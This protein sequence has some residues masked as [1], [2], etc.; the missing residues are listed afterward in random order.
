MSQSDLTSN[1]SD[2][3]EMDFTLTPCVAC[4]QTSTENEPMVGCDS[5]KG[6]FHY[7]CVGVT[8]AVKTEKHWFCADTVCQ[9]MGKKLQEKGKKVKKN[10]NR[11]T[12][13]SSTVP[14]Q[15]DKIKAM[16]EEFKRKM[17]ELDLEKILKEKEMELKLALQE[18]RLQMERDLREKE[19]S[20]EKRLLERAMEE[21]AEHLE[22]MKVM[23]Q[24]YQEVMAGM[25]DAIK[26]LKLPSQRP[27]LHGEDPQEG[28]SAVDH[29]PLRNPSVI[30]GKLLDK[31]VE[32]RP[33]KPAEKKKTSK[34]TAVAVEN[35]DTSDEDGDDNTDDEEVSEP[36]SN[37]GTVS[38]GLGQ[39]RTG[40]TRMQLTARSGVTK[41]LP[42][43]A[44]KAEDW[45]LFYGT[46]QASN[47]ACGFTDVENLVRLQECLK[48]PALES[49]RGQLILPKSV[50]K[51]MK[52]LRQLYGRPELLLQ[53]HLERVRKLESPKPDKLASFIPFGNAVEQL[54]EHLEA[55]NLQQHLINP[56][57]I[58]DLVDKLPASDKR[59]WVR[60]KR[61]KQ[62]VTLRTFT[63]FIARIVDEVCEANVS[64]EQKGESKSSMGT[65]RENKPRTKERGVLFNHGTSSGAIKLTEEKVQRKPCKACHR[66]DHRLR[67]CEDFRNMAYNDRMDLVT[68]W[69]LCNI[70]LNDHGNAPCKFKIRCNVGN[71]QQRHNPLLHPL[72]SVVGINAHI[73]AASAVLF[74]MIPVRLHCGENSVTTLA[75]LDEGASVTLIE[76]ELA[77]RLGLV[78]T[79]EQLTIT[80]TADITREE[81]GSRCMDVM[82]SAIGGGEKVLLNSVR[83]VKSLLLPKQSLDSFKISQQ[84]TYLKNLPLLS[85][86]GARPGLLIGLNNLDSFAPIEVRM[87]DSG[88]PVAVRCKLGW[89]V[90]GPKGNGSPDRN[91]VLSFHHIVSNE[92]LHDLLRSQYVLEETV[93]TTKK[94]TKEDERAL[95]ILRRTTRRVGVHFETGLLWKNNE[96][97]FPDSWQMAIKRMTQLE[98][99]LERN[100]EIYENVRKQIVEYQQKGYAHLAT[101]EELSK[102]DPSKVWYLPLNVVLNPRKPGKIRLVWD[103]AATVEGVSLNSQLLKGP[104]MLTPLVS[105]IVGFR[106][107]RVAFG[108]DVREMYHQLRIIEGD[109]QAQRFV[110]RAK[111]TDPPSV[112]VMDVATFG[113]TCSPCS[114][115]F[116][117]NLNAKENADEYPEAA[118]AILNRHYVDDY[119]D[120]T[121]TVEEAIRRARDV[122][123]VHSKG[124]FELRNWVSNSPEV[125]RSLGEEKVVQAIHFGRDKDTGN[126]RVLGIIWNPDQDTFSFSA[127]HRDHLREYLSGNEKPT[128][129]IVLSCVMGFFD[130]L[131]LL[132]P[133]T[134]HGKIL[135]QDLWRSGSSWDEKVDD[136]CWTKWK[137]WVELLPEVESIRIPRCYFGDSRWSA[138]ESLELH[139]FTDASEYAYGCVGYLRAVIED[140]VK[141][142]LI[143]SRAKVAPLKRQSVPRLELMAAVLGARMLRTI[144][145]THS[146]KFHHH[147]MWTDSQTVRSWIRSD[148][149]KFKQFVAFRVGEVLELTKPTDWYWIPS[150]LN[151]ADVL[152]KWG[153]H[154]PLDSRSFWFT[155]PEFLY[156]S[157]ETWPAQPDSV[158]ETNEEVRAFVLHHGV[159]PKQ[160]VINSERFSRWTKLLRSTAMVLRF[161]GNCR[162][163][164]NGQPLLTIMAT[165]NQAKLIKVRLPV[166]RRPLQQNELAQAET[167]LWKLVQLESFPDETAVLYNKKQG[168][169]PSIRI[170]KS[171][172]LYKLT[173]IVDENG[174]I[175]VGGRMEASE[176]LSFDKKYPIILGRNHDITS[177][178]ILHYHERCAHGNRET[179]CNELRQKF[180]IPN[181][182]TAIRQA[183]REC[184]K[185]KVWHSRPRAPKMAPLP[186][187]RISQQLRPFSA[188]GVDFL[189]PIEVTIGS[190]RVEKRWVALFTCLTVRAI[191]LEVAHSLSSQSCLMAIRRFINRFGCP[192]EFF[193]DNGTNFK[194]AS[195]E[196]MAEI[197]RIQNACA[198]GVTSVVTKWHF[199]PPGAPH[200]G[201]V[202]ERMVRSVKETMAALCDGRKLTDEI[203]LTTLSQAEEIINSRPLTY[204][205]Q[206]SAETEALTPTHFLRGI[207]TKADIMLD[208]Q[209]NAAEALRDKY[210]RSLYLA[211]RMWE[212]WSKEYLPTIN[213]RSKWFADQKD[214]QVGDLVFISDGKNRKNWTRGIV[215]EVFAGRDGRIRQANVK[216][217]G[218]VYRR[219]TANLA[220]LEIADGKSGKSDET[221]P[222]LRA[223]DC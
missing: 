6:W 60:Y 139:M 39:Q 127:E 107:R 199:N 38:Y 31:K 212:R 52:K 56:I 207:V 63:D 156:Q 49:V 118:A 95:N 136:I 41:K 3:D 119:Y 214:L 84:Y 154:S 115:Q 87:G 172:V 101:Q 203:L 188:V 27:I 18:K 46:F 217:A 131:G 170:G 10:P 143:M 1:H 75:F 177:L 196:L 98:K 71:C 209:V 147:I 169:V 173:P 197:N 195:K 53:S 210:K 133:F 201:G 7:R 42:M 116:V 91:G 73:Q 202:W 153:K 184:M 15:H 57:L 100:P 178:L 165:A 192:N 97:N 102:S 106:E 146:I 45:P 61:K 54:C 78:G 111:K 185:C 223:G 86:S 134:I 216:T 59:E 94:E 137:R 74:R 20:Q 89:T 62:E 128:K 140:T 43:F 164:K 163:K 162:R 40:P 21:K 30:V 138:V 51:V 19:L 90:Y 83:T 17:D 96:V 24:S 99:R 187:Q 48:G 34:D 65:I 150:K 5:C 135:V 123:L 204:L 55:A 50:P 158:E 92:A 175:R 181:L 215:E 180:H 109:K 144:I 126:E 103:A 58:Q 166:V 200:M 159:A 114:A 117:K 33:K 160:S 220:V 8:E 35:T 13:K 113:S 211:D 104:D 29:T 186:I 32:S 69:K 25:D 149:H 14:T 208:G 4:K 124:G 179:V 11:A 44:G 213:H 67:Y 193:S 145:D 37:G 85:Y 189:G 16:E 77:N 174:V 130:P 64:I 151:A 152:T 12:A 129:R 9:E 120:S 36:E 70:C 142:C 66:S 47:E 26:P 157:K 218:G 161:I 79:P 22:K 167:L 82:V 190:R 125:L 68:K 23:Q 205:P 122:K 121:D 108:A 222:E 183:V 80:W 191:H 219:A 176:D 198:E 28:T 110:F 206:E 221:I 81:K 2:A 141:C 112:Y 93:V 182:R 194:G 88:E 76:N 155:G 171:S 72:E 168:E 132:A 105:V 148:Q